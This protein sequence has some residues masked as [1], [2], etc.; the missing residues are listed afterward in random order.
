RDRELI[1]TGYAPG[2]SRGGRASS[3]KLRQ[4]V[5]LAHS[6]DIVLAF[7]GLTDAAEAEGFDREHLQLPMNQQRMLRALIDTG[8]PV[9]VVLAGGAPIELPFANEV[10]A[11]VHGYLP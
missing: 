5:D 3:R 9:V 10:A 2:F 11:I 1:V 8:R 4:A 6:S 7:L